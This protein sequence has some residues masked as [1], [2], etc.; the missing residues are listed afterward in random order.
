MSITTC[1]AKLLE[2]FQISLFSRI[3]SQVSQPRY[4]F[5]SCALEQ[6]SRIL[7]IVL[8]LCSINQQ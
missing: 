6:G 7:P 2:N 8:Q 4:A 1:V 3:S 5:K